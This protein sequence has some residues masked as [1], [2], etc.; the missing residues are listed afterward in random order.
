[1]IRFNLLS[2]LY[3]IFDYLQSADIRKKLKNQNRLIC[4]GFRNAVK[5]RVCFDFCAELFTSLPSVSGIRQGFHRLLF[6][7]FVIYLSRIS[8]F[9]LFV[10]R[11]HC[12]HGILIFFFFTFFAQ[13]CFIFQAEYSRSFFQRKHIVF[14]EG[15]P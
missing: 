14:Y 2:L 8:P 1:M 7:Y 13:S 4:E 6:A 11:F 10:F 3:Q 9:L 15:I 12:G 5:Q